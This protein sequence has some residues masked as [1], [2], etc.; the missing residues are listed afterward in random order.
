MGASFSSMLGPALVL[1]PLLVSAAPAGV[2]EKQKATPGPD[3]TTWASL[4]HGDSVLRSSRLDPKHG[5]PRARDTAGQSVVYLSAAASVP[6]EHIWYVMIGIPSISVWV[7]GD[8]ATLLNLGADAHGHSL[9]AVS[10]SKL[11]LPTGSLEPTTHVDGL[12]TRLLQGI[13]RNLRAFAYLR[14]GD[15]GAASDAAKRTRLIVIDEG[16]MHGSD[17]P[18]W[19]FLP[20][21][22]KFLHATSPTHAAASTGG[23]QTLGLIHMRGI[24]KLCHN[25]TAAGW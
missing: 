8:F 21:D 11:L 15:A 24:N 20:P 13:P 14:K 25:M 4:E 23:P 9:S 19:K 5:M 7:N 3:S 6:E 22:W 18:D 1:T 17:E 10:S 12:S 2:E 16:S